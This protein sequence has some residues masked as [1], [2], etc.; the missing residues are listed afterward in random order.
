MVVNGEKCDTVDSFC[1]LGDMLGMEG[2]RITA[3]DVCVEEIQGV[4]TL[5]GVQS[6]ISEDEGPNLHGMS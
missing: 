3:S 6:A 2:G 4:G 5:P 1:Y